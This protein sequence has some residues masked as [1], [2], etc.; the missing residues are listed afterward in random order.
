LDGPVFRDFETGNKREPLVGEIFCGVGV[1]YRRMELSYVHT[2]RSEEYRDQ[3]EPGDFGTVA[4]R[5][6]F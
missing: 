1:R 3:A 4:L 6:K 2:W 5:V